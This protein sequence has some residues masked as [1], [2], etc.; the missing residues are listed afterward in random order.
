MII[1]FFFLTSLTVTRF[2][3]NSLIL[4]FQ[5][6]T[7][8]LNFNCCGGENF[9]FPLSPVHTSLRYCYNQAGFKL[10]LPI[11][12]EISAQ[13]E[14]SINEYTVR[15]HERGVIR[16]QFGKVWISHPCSHDY[17]KYTLL[18][19]PWLGEEISN[20]LVFFIKVQ[21]KRL[22]LSF[23]KINVQIKRNYII[24]YRLNHFPVA[25]LFDLLT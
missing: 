24:A 2:V 1:F 16:G 12:Q 11:T 5:P 18:S 21:K 23:G 8:S 17:Y 6:V 19:C 22:R 13:I 7:R 14:S 25:K 10:I 4:N 3:D 9:R 15:L 20:C